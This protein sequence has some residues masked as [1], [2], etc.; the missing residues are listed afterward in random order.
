MH[1]LSHW[2][3]KTLLA[4]MMMHKT[5]HVFSCHVGLKQVAV[6]VLMCATHTHTHKKYVLYF[7]F[8]RIMM[9]M[10]KDVKGLIFLYVLLCTSF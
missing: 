2:E 6:F 9:F 7:V 1:T 8:K 4:M 5:L 3:T 10:S